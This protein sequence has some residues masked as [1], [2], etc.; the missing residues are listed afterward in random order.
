MPNGF[1]TFGGTYLIYSPP[2]FLLGAFFVQPR[3][4]PL[5]WKATEYARPQNP[6]GLEQLFRLYLL[7]SKKYKTAALPQ[8]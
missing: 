4:L 8:G 6:S 1:N 3:P 2:L 5:R 7:L